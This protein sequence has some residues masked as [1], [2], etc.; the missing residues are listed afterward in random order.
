MIV[1]VGASAGGVESVSAFI[2][3][4]PADFGAAVLVVIHIPSHTPTQLDKVLARHSRLP[5]RLA[6]DGG[7]VEP[8]H[9][10]APPTDRHL[11][12]Q[13]GVMRLTR[14]PKEGRVRPSIDVLFR[15]AAVEFGTRI[16]GVVMSGMLD[17]GTAG[18]WAIKDAGG[19]ALV[20]CPD[21][22]MHRSMPDSAIEHVQIDLIAPV[23]ELA[24]EVIKM[25]HQPAQAEPSCA[26]T[27]RHFVENR[28]A[29]E[30]NGLQLGVMKLGQV[31][32]YTCPNCHGVLVQI[33][34]GPIVRFRCH[35]GHSFSL[36]ALLAE[37]N[38]SIDKG[39]W[40]TLRAV[41]ERIMLLRQMAG[42]AHVA[43]HEQACRQWSNQAAD[44]DQR[45]QAL[46]ELALNGQLLGQL[47][48][49]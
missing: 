21:E 3:A 31:A 7:V 8:G 42:L 39:L 9:I 19:K 6:V 27:A 24:R 25:V 35:T 38:S 33:E 5:V 23:A 47:Q 29:M 18:L 17:D 45:I 4:L 22:A 36:K 48:E 40:D 32:G 34:E 28:I 11:M 43:G 15:S 49:E 2:N 46:R 41:E 37:V 10:Y 16:I 44:A 13:G 1:V 12:L 14:G 20:Q 26:S 30:G